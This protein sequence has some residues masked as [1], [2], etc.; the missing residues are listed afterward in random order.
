ADIHAYHWEGV[1]QR[2]GLPDTRAMLNGL[3]D[4]TPS[5]LDAVASKLPKG[6]PPTLADA[7]FAGVRRSADTLA[8]SLANGR[9]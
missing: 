2:H 5:A 6:F 9:G 7:I 4:A 3:V 1:G 8:D